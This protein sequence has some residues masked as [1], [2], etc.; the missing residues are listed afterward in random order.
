VLHTNYVTPD[1]VD[2]ATEAGA[3]VVEKGSL[4]ALRRAI[5]E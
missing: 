2:A 3:R 1:V 5:T 4:H